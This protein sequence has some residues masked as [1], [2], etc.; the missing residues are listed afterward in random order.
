MAMATAAM[1]APTKARHKDKAPPVIDEP[2]T[3]MQAMAARRKSLA[4]IGEPDLNLAPITTLA[5][6]AMAS[7]K[8]WR[9]DLVAIGIDAG[10][11]YSAFVP[12]RLSRARCFS[13]S[14]LNL[15]AKKTLAPVSPLRTAPSKACARLKVRH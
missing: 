15:S 10:G 8:G 2:P 3:T 6:P 12:A 4:S 1:R 13:F 5:T 7:E 14:R 9:R 11:R